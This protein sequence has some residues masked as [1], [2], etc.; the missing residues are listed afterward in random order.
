LEGGEFIAPKAGFPIHPKSLERARAN[1]RGVG[2]MMMPARE[3]RFVKEVEAMLSQSTLCAHLV[4]WAV[5]VRQ[6]H[7]A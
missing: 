6:K 4:R 3:V 5:E 1:Y 2:E 7:L